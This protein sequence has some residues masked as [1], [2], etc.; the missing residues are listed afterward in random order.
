MTTN[1]CQGFGVY[2]FQKAPGVPLRGFGA[3]DHTSP[4]GLV[5]L[6][7]AKY[8]TALTPG[9]VGQFV[10]V[11]AQP[12]SQSDVATDIYQAFVTLFANKGTWAQSQ[13]MSQQLVNAVRNVAPED[14]SLPLSTSAAASLQGLARQAYLYVFKR[15]PMGSHVMPAAAKTA[16]VSKTSPLVSWANVSK[17]L[18]PAAGGKKPDPRG[19]GSGGKF[20]GYK[21]PEETR[22]LVE[23]PGSP[24][25][26]VVADTGA[27]GGGADPY[28]GPYVDEAPSGAGTPEWVK[29][30]AIG[31]G[32]VALAAILYVATKKG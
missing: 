10:D 21:L 11:L 18:T 28:P 14:V 12:Y 30:V 7:I 16:V 4:N 2:E 29:P 15:D 3:F 8:T 25:G 17:S 32:V 27:G 6:L 22:K 19:S 13:A 24:G 23:D 26:Q 31:A 1:A 20:V 9:Y 5:Q